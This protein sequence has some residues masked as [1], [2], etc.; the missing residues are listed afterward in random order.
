[1]RIAFAG[2]NYCE[3]YDPVPAPH[4]SV[5]MTLGRTLAGTFASA[6]IDASW[7]D[8]L[9]I[10]LVETCPLPDDIEEC[11]CP[12]VGIVVDWETWSDALFAHAPGLDV[13][14]ADQSGVDKM[15]PFFPGKLRTLVP[16]GNFGQITSD[17]AAT[18]ISQRAWD[19]TFV[20]GLLP[21]ERFAGRVEGLRHLYPLSDRFRVRILARV[22]REEMV[23]AMCDSKILFNHAALPVQQG[24]NARNFEAGACRAVVMGERHNA[25][26]REF[27]TDDELL[28]YDY[29]TMGD[30][31]A[32]ALEHADA[33]QRMADRY[34]EKVTA[35]LMPRLL[36]ALRSVVEDDVR[37]RGVRTPHDRLIGLI[38]GFGNWGED[39]HRM[40]HTFDMTS[41]AVRAAAVESPDDAT[42]ANL[43]GVAA[44]ELARELRRLGHEGSARKLTAHP[45]LDPAAHWRRAGELDGEF[46]APLYNLGRYYAEDGDDARAAATLS[47]A[48]QCLVT[49]GGHAMARRS[50][51]Y[52][53]WSARASG[54][55]R[56]LAGSYNA[57][58]FLFADAEERA[59]YRS[60]VL[61]W[62]VEECLGVL[63]MRRS[64]VERALRQ[65]MAAAARAPELSTEALRKALAICVAAGDDDLATDILVKLTR[66]N[67]LDLPFREQ[68]RDAHMRAGTTDAALDEETRLLTKAVLTPRAH[69]RGSL[70]AI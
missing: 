2:S 48:R 70:D 3:Q 14:L 23:A 26:L 29:D 32:W 68:L 12:T 6:G 52:P 25:A 27:F 34:A 40:P 20:G 57:A 24:V 43:A 47:A 63:S 60:R 49:H 13:I 22:E 9:V 33:A 53:V 15:S 36:A 62:R 67:P 16:V 64:S 66:L 39:A 56:T 44:A 38:C 41:R 10:V 45:H 7:P 37:T 11:P 17:L 31:V 69:E 21:T 65:Y 30:A 51:L 18:P 59:E 19:V 1:M 55:D 61:M 28:F 8:V 42:L 54:L 50:S 4:E 46:A 58:R 5:W 35:P